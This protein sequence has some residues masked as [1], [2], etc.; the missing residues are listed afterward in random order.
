MLLLP[1]V[2][3]GAVINHHTYVNPTKTKQNKKKTL[4]QKGAL[5]HTGGRGKHAG[6]Q[7][8]VTDRN[9]AKTAQEN[10]DTN[11]GTIATSHKEETEAKRDRE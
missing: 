7:T 5:C 1:C 4:P 8:R 9:E 2:Y 11:S 10:T 6:K 3:T